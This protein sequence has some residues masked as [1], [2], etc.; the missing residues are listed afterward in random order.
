MLP[1]KKT[2]GE[3]DDV[4][5]GDVIIGENHGRI[6]GIFRDQRDATGDMIDLF[7]DDIII[8]GDGSDLTIEDVITIT[9]ENKIIWTIVWDHAVSL[10][11][12]GRVIPTAC[13][14]DIDVVIILPERGN[15]LPGR[16]WAEDRY[17]P[18]G[19]I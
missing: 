11:A 5:V 3:T 2:Y 7:E 4:D 16:N 12:Q 10:N 1:P 8:E 6:G 13:I 15:R 17:A 14:R 9:D 18:H 19:K